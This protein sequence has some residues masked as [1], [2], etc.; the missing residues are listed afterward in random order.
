MLKGKF[1][2]VIVITDQFT[3]TIENNLTSVSENK[4]PSATLTEAEQR[5]F[6][7][8]KCNANMFACLESAGSRLV[9][10]DVC[11]GFFTSLINHQIQNAIAYDLQ[12]E[13]GLSIV[14]ERL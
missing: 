11:S 3:S 8:F 1:L 13:Y 12:E 9:Q 4:P 5:I 7:I 14:T 6:Q 10:E 2:G